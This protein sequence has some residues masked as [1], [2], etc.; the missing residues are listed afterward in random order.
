MTGFEVHTTEHILLV[1]DPI[2]YIDLAL[3][4][5]GA[6]KSLTQRNSPQNFRT[7]CR[8]GSI[9]L[10]FLG[11]GISFR[12]KVLGP[13]SGKN[14]I[15]GQHYKKNGNDAKGI[16]VFPPSLRLIRMAYGCE[17]SFADVRIA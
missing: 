2:I 5:Y 11:N 4:N 6:A 15:G 3:A 10:L 16:H 12:A 8:P 7:F 1:I 13:I 14:W 9:E 17:F